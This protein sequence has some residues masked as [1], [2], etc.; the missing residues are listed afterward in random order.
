MIR[1]HRKRRLGA[2]D[3]IRGPEV[4][5]ICVVVLGA[6]LPAASFAV[7]GG[8]MTRACT[9]VAVSDDVTEFETRDQTGAK[10]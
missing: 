3:V 9:Q 1:I 2:R 5:V 6:G 10:E 4:G 7:L 8:A